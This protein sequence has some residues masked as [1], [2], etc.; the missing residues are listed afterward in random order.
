MRK[1]RWQIRKAKRKR[2]KFEEKWGKLWGGTNTAM[3]K[4]YISDNFP[5]FSVSFLAALL[6]CCQ[7][8]HR[9]AQGTLSKCPNT[10]TIFWVKCPHP[11]I[12]Y[13]YV[14][15]VSYF[16]IRCGVERKDQRF[17]QHFDSLP[18]HA[19]GAYSIVHLSMPV[20]CYHIQ[21]TTTVTQDSTIL[22]SAILG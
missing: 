7:C 22:P 1:V 10:K 15:R 8:F 9:T 11:S 17:F 20:H 14:S 13:L 2:G 6:P 21:C 16:H 19:G 18:I 4:C 5:H 12:I 3:R